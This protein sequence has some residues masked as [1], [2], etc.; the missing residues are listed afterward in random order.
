[1]SKDY[2]DIGLNNRLRAINGI[3]GRD[4]NAL[5]VSNFEVALPAG[6]VGNYQLDRITAN[7]I[8]GGTLELGGRDN[9]SGIFS[10]KDEGGTERVAMDKDGLSVYDGSITIE[11]ADGTTSFDSSGVVSAAN[12]ISSAVTKEAAFNQEFSGTTPTALTDGTISFDLTRDSLCLFMT[13]LIYCVKQGGTGDYSARGKVQLLI[14]DVEKQQVVEGGRSHDGY[15]EGI[16]AVT[17]SSSAMHTLETLGSGSHTFKLAAFED[18]LG[19]DPIFVVYKY[20]MT[21]IKLGT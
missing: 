20:K 8:Y 1:M 12:F 17:Y 11:N 5:N 3:A 19:G 15:A 2:S 9:V 14:D 7:H 21:Y 16:G 13:D 4:R 10:L 6:A 18:I